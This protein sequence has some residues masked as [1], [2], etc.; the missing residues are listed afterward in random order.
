MNNVTAFVEVR[1][2]TKSLGTWLISSGLGA[3][4]TF[5]AGGAEYRFR[6]PPETNLLSVHFDRWREF[7][8]D[9]YPGTIF[10]RIFQPRAFVQSLE[11]MNHGS[12]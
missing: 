10:Q 11:R 3:P 9:I 5:F 4:Q 8:H 1:E 6:D 2:D 12:P 7:H